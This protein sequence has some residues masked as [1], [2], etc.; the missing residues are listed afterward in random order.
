MRIFVCAECG[1]LL[2]MNCKMKLITGYIEDD[3][4]IISKVHRKAFW[5][6]VLIV[7]LF[8]LVCMMVSLAM[9]VFG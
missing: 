6:T 8:G 3:K 9:A 2:Q 5:T 7:V 4:K 1:L